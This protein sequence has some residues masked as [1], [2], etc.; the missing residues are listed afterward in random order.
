VTKWLQS[1]LRR[2]VCILLA[3]EEPLHA[4]Q[5]KAR[6]GERYDERI[7]PATFRRAL[8]A[9]VETGHL[10]VESD[11]IHDAYALTEAAR[12]MVE[13]QFEWMREHVRDGP[14]E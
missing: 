2:D 7:D 12:S 1:G 8:D 14:A 6:I 9:L 10:E 3:G 4:Q 5:L 13:A 11:G